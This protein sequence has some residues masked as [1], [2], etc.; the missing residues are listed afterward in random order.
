MVLHDSRALLQALP[1]GVCTID[2]TGRIVSLNPEAE[3]LLGWGEA[4]CV[5]MSLHDV[6]ACWLD[7]SEPPQ[8]ICPITQVLQTGRPV[9]TAA[10]TL[11]GRDG[12]C[13]PVEYT[14]MPLPTVGNPGAVVSFRDLRR[15]R[16]TEQDLV[17]LASVS[18]ESPFPIVELDAEAHLT[19]ANP[20]MM[21]LMEQYGFDQHA[22]PA[23]L[24][25]D[26]RGIVRECI[27]A[28]QSR[29]GVAGRAADKYFEW[30]FCPIPYTGL[31]RGYGVDLTERRQA[32]QTL[33]EARDAVLEAWR[34][35]SEFMANISHELR[36]PLNGIIGMTELV[37]DS[38][39]TPEQYADLMI[40]REAADTLRL[41]V[42]DL[43]DFAKLET[44]QLVLTNQTFALR[45]RLAMALR[46]LAQRAQLKGLT[47]TTDIA[48]QVRDTLCGDPD[49]LCQV[50][51]SLVQNAIKFTARGSITIRV[52]LM[53][54]SDDEVWLHWTVT[55]TGIGLSAGQRRLIFE[56]FRQGDGSSTR[57]YG[58]MGL[59]LTIAAQLVV[60]MGGE[61][62]AESAGPGT[63]STFHFTTR[64]GVQPTPVLQSADR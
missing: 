22:C 38:P 2:S 31:V 56:A 19:Y 44:G 15:Q 6:M 14:C 10:M 50:L 27:L 40:V 28:G 53:S 12:S 25:S 57:P 35:K 24:P 5:G 48:P 20:A 17:R 8:M 18:E 45:T 47:L 33:R 37:L 59:G 46:P 42:S 62:W 9:W 16:Q 49:R 43:L 7:A 64:F 58:G 55:D 60:M 41:L 29:T 3:R 34:L 11:Q 54:Q 51:A 36:T 30:T 1:L 39:L 21:A 23:I 13:F 4:A 52:T 32:E 61:I 63:G 26:L